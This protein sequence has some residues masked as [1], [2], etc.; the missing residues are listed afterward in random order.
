MI[1]GVS[2]WAVILLHVG[3]LLPALT[4]AATQAPDQGCRT[5]TAKERADA[6]ARG[7]PGDSYQI[8]PKDIEATQIGQNFDQWYARIKAMSPCNKN[9][10]NLACRTRNTGAQV[11]GTTASKWNSI[12]CHPNNKTA[13]FPTVAHGFAA[14]I[15]LLRR[16]CG[17][18]GRC[19][20]NSVVQ[21]WTAVAADRP[22]YAAF[23]SRAAGIPANQVYNPNDIDMMARL[24]LAKACFEGGALPFSADDLKKGLAMAAGGEK[25]PVPSNVGELLNESLTGSYSGGGSTFPGLT[26][27]PGA[28]SP[29]SQPSV[30]PSTQQLLTPPPPPPTPVSASQPLPQPITS[31]SIFVSSTSSSETIDQKE[32][33]SKAV[34]DLLDALAAPTTPASPMAVRSPLVLN[35]SVGPSNAAH[36]SGKAATSTSNAPNVSMVPPSAETFSASYR[37][38]DLRWSTPT[39][40]QPFWRDIETMIR[41]IIDLL[42]RL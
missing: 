12:G 1:L 29:V 8:C 42:K 37:S 17:Q 27:L 4:L 15:E 22:A 26:P 25:V 31:S 5:P 20:I 24:A 41:S 33:Q 7:L 21:Q 23:V 38:P 10:C 14:H 11:C 19:T 39:L 34:S 40:F 30:T 13:I 3:M 6:V 36:L 9:T 32:P 28:S 18:R 2:R 16:Y 35:E